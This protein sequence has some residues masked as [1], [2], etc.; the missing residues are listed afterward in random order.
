M[1]SSLA[2]A[3]SRDSLKAEMVGGDIVSLAP[4]DHLMVGKEMFKLLLPY[5]GSE[6]E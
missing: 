3:V 5:L 1:P 4:L 2:F 6:A